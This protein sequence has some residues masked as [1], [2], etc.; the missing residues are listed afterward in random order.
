MAPLNVLPLLVELRA[1][2]AGGVA[3]A[4][5]LLEACRRRTPTP[6]L[7][8]AARGLLLGGSLGS[9]AADLPDDEPLAGLLV[10][11]LALAERAGTGALDA[12]SQA[13]AVVRDEQEL[14]RRL[15]VR[16]A[17][18][19]GSLRV[20]AAVPLGAVGILLL[21][22]PA[23]VAFYGRPAGRVSG[24]LALLLALLARRWA[25][26]IVASV[27]SRA[28]A[29]D[30]LGSVAGGAA[31][32]AELV[33]IGLAAGLSV[34]EVLDGLTRF[35]PPAAR[36]VL[37]RACRRLAAGWPL[38][39][40]LGDGPLASVGQA[41][42][43]ARRWGSP[44]EPGLRALAASLRADRRAAADEAAEHAELR[45][46]FPTTLLTLPSFLL[47]V[48]PPLVWSGVRW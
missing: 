33:A 11:S 34:E 10:R 37:A 9:V 30:P 47:A 39:E 29:A 18:A 5:A 36:P 15:A 4:T 8:R 7:E 13:E 2:L 45:L 12:V 25:S 19:R 43:A 6:A 23:A 17:R 35:G 3:P 40:A 44:A 41:L 46:V 32:T 28:A 27:P 31:E 22:D 24:G 21:V 38:D 48:V 16:T 42:D 26:R 14:A 1:A 20:L